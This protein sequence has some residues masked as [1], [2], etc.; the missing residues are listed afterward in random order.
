[1]LKPTSLNQ[2]AGNKALL[3]LIGQLLRNHNFPQLSL[4]SGPMGIGKSTTANIIAD[5]LTDNDKSNVHMFNFG[6]KQNLME[7]EQAY[8][9][10][11]PLQ[12]IAL[13]FDEFHYLDYEQQKLFP[14]LLDTLPRNV[15]VILTTT[16]KKKI[17]KPIVSRTQLFEFRYLTN[18]DMQTLLIQYSNDVYHTSCSTEV[19]S[20]LIRKA[21][22]IPRDLLNSVDLLLSANVDDDS[23]ADIFGSITD[24][25]IMFFFATLKTASIDFYS[26]VTKI[27]EGMDHIKLKEIRDF[28]SRFLLCRLN[29]EDISLAKIYTEQLIELYTNNEIVNI[30]KALIHTNEEQFLLDM[31]QLNMI[32]TGTSKSALTG[33][34]IAVVEKKSKQIIQTAPQQKKT[35]NASAIRELNL[36]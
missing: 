17:L 8:F 26:A 31:L 13:I 24:N 29:T 23:V 3:Y 33:Q 30:T 5:T 4:L 21:R 34:Q 32:L 25:N 16:E 28:W 14:A 36:K 1:M 12:P 35:L 19:Q 27:N 6:D 7:I 18:S 22:G 20:L 2:L 11:A 9:K 15:Y 10:S